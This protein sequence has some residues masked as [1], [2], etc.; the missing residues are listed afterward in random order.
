[1]E[2]KEAYHPYQGLI[3]GFHLR[4]NV[5]S[6]NIFLSQIIPYQAPPTQ[7]G[8]QKSKFFGEKVFFGPKF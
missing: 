8:P 3:Q 4:L 7:V 2:N 6:V 1:M 5:S